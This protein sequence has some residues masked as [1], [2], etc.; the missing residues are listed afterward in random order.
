[1][2]SGVSGENTASN[3]YSGVSGGNTAVTTHHSVLTFSVIHI[4]GKT[5]PMATPTFNVILWPS[6]WKLRYNHWPVQTFCVILRP[7]IW[8]LRQNHWPFRHSVLS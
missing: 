5:Q 3:L 2:Y 7:S 1:L 8:Q 4:T 6:T